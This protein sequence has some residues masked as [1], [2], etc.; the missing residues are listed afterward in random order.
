MKNLKRCPF[1]GEIAKTHSK[2]STMSDFASGYYAEVE[3]TECEAKMDRGTIILARRKKES[4]ADSIKRA[5]EMM[6]MALDGAIAAWNK[7]V[8]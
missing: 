6:N 5:T 1:C 2:L 8:K 4:K 7:R 3:C